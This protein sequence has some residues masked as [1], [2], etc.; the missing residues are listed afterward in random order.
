MSARLEGLAR[1]AA[2]AAAG[3]LFA[4][5][6]LAA[7]ALAAFGQ[8]R[9][10][11]AGPHPRQSVG[12]V[13]WSALVQDDPFLY[14]LHR[15]QLLGELEVYPYALSDLSGREIDL[16]G[17]EAE[18]DEA[19]ANARQK[20]DE[21]TACGVLDTHSRAECEA[22][23]KALEMLPADDYEVNEAPAGDLLSEETGVDAL[24]YYSGE[25][26]V[27]GLE[28]IFNVADRT[29]A[30]TVLLPYLP[31]PSADALVFDYFQLTMIW[32]RD[33]GK[34]FDYALYYLDAPAPADTMLTAWQ[35]YLGLDALTDWAA[36]P[37]DDPYMTALRS[38]QAGVEVTLT[39]AP[40][41][42]FNE[43]PRQYLELRCTSTL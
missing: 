36:A 7:P 14:G 24:L 31:D 27:C 35:R 26:N 12:S 18:R 29:R 11:L 5:A 43:M 28:L 33:S 40:F 22:V 41:T 15:A 25:G 9:A 10:L 39:V 6:V 30:S 1:R 8:V 37:T 34:V 20:L 13:F 3:A 17:D 32:L 21:L 42:S 38:A 2:P 16:V 19:L 4:A 23:F